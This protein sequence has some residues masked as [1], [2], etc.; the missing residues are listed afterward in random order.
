MVP[1]Y[2]PA[3]S[4]A[5]VDDL[6]KPEVLARMEK[7]IQGTGRDSGNMMMSA[8]VMRDYRLETAGYRLR[9]GT[10]TEF[11]GNYDCAIVARA[12][13]VVPVWSSHFITRVGNMRP[14]DEPK[15]LLGQANEGSLV[16][17]RGW[18][19]RAP[20]TTLHV[21][22]RMHLGMDAV[23]TMGNAVKRENKT[24]R[25]AARAWIEQN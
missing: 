18:V 10:L 2:V 7:T 24:P 6:K 12:W 17:S 23:E 16:A 21:V 8:D 22:R 14:I 5:Q 9:P 4:V 3:T 13:F 1:E 15:G 11:H 19:G 20:E 25:Q